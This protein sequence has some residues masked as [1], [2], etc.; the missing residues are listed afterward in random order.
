[1]VG[2]KKIVAAIGNFD[3]VH[4]GHQFLLQQTQELAREQQAALGVVLFEPHP[5]RFF[6]P[7]DPAFLLT[8]PAKRDA[9]LRAVGVDEIFALRFDA[10]LASMTPEDFVLEELKTRLKLSGVVAGADFR[11]GKDRAGG[12]AA[13]EKLSGEAGMAVKLVGILDGEKGEKFGSSAI[14]QALRN[15]EPEDAARMLGRPWSATGVVAEGQKVGR[16]IGF[17]TANMI[18][19]DLIAPREG[20]YA[21]RA[22]VGDEIYDAVSNFGRRPTVGSGAPLLET[23]LLDFDGDLYGREIEIFFVSFLRDERKFDGLDALKAQ[24]SDDCEA[25]R[26][27]LAAYSN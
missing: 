19:G 3:G 2:G 14:R 17:P 26:K 10:A 25:A 13:L 27:R 15:G 24:I 16:T 5:R 12:G 23:Y 20:V 4:R 9:L 21:T 8:T 7:D 22:R 6:R 11:F 18:L 1:M